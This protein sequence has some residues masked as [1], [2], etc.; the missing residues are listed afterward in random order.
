MH[1]DLWTR[2]HLLLRVKCILSFSGSS[3][4]LTLKLKNLR[5]ILWVIQQKI[6]G[7]TLTILVAQPVIKDYLAVYHKQTTI[8]WQLYYFFLQTF[9][10]LGKDSI[11]DIVWSHSL[12]LLDGL[13]LSGLCHRN[14]TF[15]GFY[16]KVGFML[17]SHWRG[18]ICVLW[19][20]SGALYN[21]T[22]SIYY[23]SKRHEKKPSQHASLY[24][25]KLKFSAT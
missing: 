19:W 18:K 3:S 6:I 25:R 1:F 8:M 14:I 7:E 15:K 11:W 24:V 13:R 21:G 17:L 10:V 12:P 16:T 9:T 4:Q 2:F 22:L 20:F 23:I 5:K